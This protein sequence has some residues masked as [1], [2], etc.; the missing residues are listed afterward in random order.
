[1]KLKNYAYWLL[2]FVFLLPISSSARKIALCAVAT[3]RYDVFAA[4]MIESAR[5]YFCTEHEVHYFV[6]TDGSIPAAPDVTQVFQKRLGWPLDTLMRFS[7]YLEHRQLFDSFDYIYATDADML[8]VS[9]VGSEILSDLVGTKHP[10]YIKKRGTYEEVNK[11]STA[12]VSRNE[13]KYYFAGGFYGGAKDNFFKMMETVVDNIEKD[14]QKDFIAVWHDESHLNRYF[15]DNP[16][17]KVLSPAYCCP[18]NI[19][20]DYYDPSILRLKKK[21]VALDK[22]HSELRK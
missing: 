19:H 21:L 17:T 5:K 15:I 13:G 20:P 3:G 11:E 2:F 14:L 16:P 4:Q 9:P 1:M 6:F 12:Y 7:I 10:G 22:N 18:E 8:F